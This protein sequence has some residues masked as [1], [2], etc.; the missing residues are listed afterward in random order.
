MNPTIRRL[1]E[2]IFS[3][4]LQLKQHPDLHVF[5]ECYGHIGECSVRINSAD[6]NY[7]DADTLDRTRLFS[8]TAYYSMERV[9]YDW[10]TPDERH[11]RCLAQLTE[12]LAN[13]RHFADTSA[14]EARA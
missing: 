5:F 1:L 11:A 9:G 10:M 4:C 8:A 7:Q 6:T 13:L 12:L 2:E 14:Q 3:L